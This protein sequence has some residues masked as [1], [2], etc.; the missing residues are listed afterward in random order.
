[1]DL[2]QVNQEKCINCG[3]CADACPTEFITMVNQEPK[4]TGVSCI[5]CGIRL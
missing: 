3:L 1:M 5:A 4:A 2:I